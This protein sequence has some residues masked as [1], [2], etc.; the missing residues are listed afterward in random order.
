MYIS[1]NIY[2]E[3]NKCE[4]C[5]NNNICKWTKVMLK[6]NETVNLLRDEKEFNC[7]VRVEVFCNSF[8][9]M[10]QQQNGLGVWKVAN[11]ILY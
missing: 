1:N 10:E 11:R 7:P 3:K 5:K 4:N 9:R 2:N 8:E 6:M